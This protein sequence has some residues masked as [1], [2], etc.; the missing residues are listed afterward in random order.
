LPEL[1]TGTLEAYE[2][3]ALELARDSA[4]LAAL[5]QKLKQNLSSAPL[6]DADGFRRAIEEAFIVMHKQQSA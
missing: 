1:V 2:I 6:F 5:K 3:R 4:K